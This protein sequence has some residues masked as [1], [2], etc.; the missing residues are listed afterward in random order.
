MPGY[1]AEISAPTKMPC[2]DF[3]MQASHKEEKSLIS[4]CS[5]SCNSPTRDG[6]PMCRKRRCAREPMR[7][8]ESA[9]DSRF[10]TGITF[11]F[12]QPTTDD[13]FHI[14]RRQFDLQPHMDTHVGSPAETQRSNSPEIDS[15]FVDSESESELDDS[16]M[17][18]TSPSSPDEGKVKRPTSSRSGRKQK[19]CACCGCTS[20]PL[21]RDMGK[22]QPLCNACGIRW[23]KY[24]VI[25]EA[26]QY[27]PCKQERE[28]KLCKRCSAV[29]PPA[30]KRIRA[31][32]PQTVP[33]KVA[34]VVP[35]M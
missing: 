15:A 20:T 6:S 21:W 13:F 5:T 1:T 8:P 27:V 28:R 33:R 11:C 31:A 25:C 4:A 19:Q 18:L 34:P 30:P 32:S 10:T 22:N 2:L 7:G 12:G 9:D 26:C 23:K 3:T 24:G 14:I 17:D 16:H 35:V 29:L